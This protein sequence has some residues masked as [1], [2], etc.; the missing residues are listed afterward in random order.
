L[1]RHVPGINEVIRDVEVN[2][3]STSNCGLRSPT[4]D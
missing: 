2:E 3:P 4:Y 1:R